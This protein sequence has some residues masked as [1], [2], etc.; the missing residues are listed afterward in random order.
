MPA[1]APMLGEPRGPA[2]EM[3]MTP[4][5]VRQVVE[6]AGFERQPLVELPPY[7]YVAVFHKGD[8]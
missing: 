7:H 3:R 8:D 1:G 2:T 4:E 5:A 6:P